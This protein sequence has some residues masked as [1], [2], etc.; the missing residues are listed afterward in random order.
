MAADRTSAAGSVVQTRHAAV[1]ISLLVVL[2]T[3]S[4]SVGVVA[5]DSGGP[6]G[7]GYTWTDSN[8]AGGPTYDWIDIRATG[9]SISL[10]DDDYEQVSLPFDFSFYGVDHSTVYISSNGYLT[11]GTD[12]TDY[13]N[14]AIPSTNQPND[15]IAPFWDDLDPR[16]SGTQ[17]HYLSD[18]TNGRFIVQYTDIR[19]YNYRWSTDR[20]TFQ[21][22]LYED[23][24]IKYQ[25]QDMLGGGYGVT[26]ATVGIEA[27]AGTDGLTVA[28]NEPYVENGLAVLI[29][30]NAQPARS[31]RAKFEIG[32]ASVDPSPIVLGEQV[33]VSVD[34]TNVGGRDG[35]FR[36]FL[37]DDRTILSNQ[38]LVSIAEGETQT[39]EFDVSFKRAGKHRLSLSHTPVGEVEVFT[40]EQ[41]RPGDLTLRHAYL[42]RS[43]VESGE[44]YDVVAVVENRDDRPGTLELEYATATNNTTAVDEALTVTLDTGETR[45]VRL[46]RVAPSVE[47][48]TTL[49]WQVNDR[50]AGSL[51][52]V[53]GDGE[54]ETG[55]IDAYVTR[56][57]VTTGENY[58]VVAT[59]HNGND[60][61]SRFFVAYK[62]SDG[63]MTLRMVT[64]APDQTAE[65]ART[66][67]SEDSGTVTWTVGSVEAGT[68]TSTD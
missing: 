4:I 46:D 3:I 38:G 35:E 11:F 44:G 50:T 37:S 1:V 42:T 40:R 62:P 68:V 48:E 10:S 18:A 6:D 5:A 17:I 41:L 2:S 8:E 39:F 24:R 55:V 15:Y 16:G 7:F 51:I 65:F 47:S 52:V 23:G 22:I 43:T 14:D 49:E 54:P 32:D 31:N 64:V 59:V 25:Y 26:S 30:P 66:I 33:T 61:E 53:P 58:D 12:R 13:T 36:A 63:P 19:H 57:N 27:P 67:T 29:D 28:Y 9:T 56:A 21:V 34:V 20:Y 45:D 60:Q